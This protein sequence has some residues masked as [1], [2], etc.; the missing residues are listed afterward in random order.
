MPMML[1]WIE[2]VASRAHFWNS[3]GMRHHLSAHDSHS[4]GAI[5]L[6]DRRV[7][8]H[9]QRCSGYEP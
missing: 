8:G 7:S 3:R 2:L 4:V 6:L 9:P 1:L 5:V